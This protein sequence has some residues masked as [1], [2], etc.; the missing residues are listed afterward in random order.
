MVR[1]KVEGNEQQ[2]RQA[3][4]EG[5]P[6]KHGGTLGSSKQRDHEPR[7]SHPEQKTTHPLDR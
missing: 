7:G 6:S 5:E 2:R 3:A 1:K 4:R